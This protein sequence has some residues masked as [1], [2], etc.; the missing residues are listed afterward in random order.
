VV[1]LREELR[2]P[3]QETVLVGDAVWLREELSDCEGL[4][5]GVNDSVR[6]A[7]DKV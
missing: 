4:R 2:E 3:V 5:E 7:G 6:E 1:R